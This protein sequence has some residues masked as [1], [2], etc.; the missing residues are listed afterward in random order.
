MLMIAESILM[1]R[2]SPCGVVGVESDAVE[3]RVTESDG[4]ESYSRAASNAFRKLPQ[5]LSAAGSWR[6]RDGL[7]RRRGFGRSRLAFGLLP[8]QARVSW[9]WSRL[10]SAGGGGD[11]FAPL[12]LT[13]GRLSVELRARAE[14]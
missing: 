5:I 10:L 6:R 11:R 9:P 1:G 12:G 7:G 2:S 14:V 3:P 4:F 13:S 8:G